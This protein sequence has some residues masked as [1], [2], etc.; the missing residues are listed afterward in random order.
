ME[1]KKTIKERLIAIFATFLVIASLVA[2]SFAVPWQKVHAESIADKY[3]DYIDSTFGE[4]TSFVVESILAE[5]S[6][7]L[8][9][10][11]VYYGVLFAL[12]AI[13]PLETG[14]LVSADAI[15]SE[16]G[17]YYYQNKKQ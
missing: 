6:Q 10:K 1:N 13:E 7:G 15:T 9:G 17:Y 2:F 3:E 4:G 8:C 11:G 5:I 16:Q 12:N 14:S